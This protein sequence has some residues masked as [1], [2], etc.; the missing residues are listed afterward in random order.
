VFQALQRKRKV[1]RSMNR[2]FS[3]IL[4]L[5]ALGIVLLLGGYLI[6]TWGQL[7]G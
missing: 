4:K 2:I 3:N 6:F 5:S 1:G 7:K